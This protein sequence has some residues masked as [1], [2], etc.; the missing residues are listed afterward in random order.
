MGP[1]AIPIRKDR[2]ASWK[3]F[4][5]ELAGP[6]NEEFREFNERYGLTAHRA[7]LETMPDGAAFALVE[8]EGPGAQSFL[9]QL[10][11]SNHPFDSWFRD[12][13]SDAHGIDFKNPPQLSQPE[14]LIDG[15]A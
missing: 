15:H 9:Q 13:I 12:Q 8:H 6:R 3:A 14:L 7:A 11:R 4:A 10:S 1:I 2:V 5:Q